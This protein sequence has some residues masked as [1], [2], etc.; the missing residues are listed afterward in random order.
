VDNSFEVVLETVDG[1]VDL[2]VIFSRNWTL[3]DVFKT[4][5]NVSEVGVVAE[6]TLSFVTRIVDLTMFV[7]VGDVAFAIFPALLL[8]ELVV[9][10]SEVKILVA[11][12]VD[13]TV[14]FPLVTDVIILPVV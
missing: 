5:D 3:E 8:N 13:F 4:L 2:T 10:V 6:I 7:A 9:P 12:D 11:F 1:A 14:E